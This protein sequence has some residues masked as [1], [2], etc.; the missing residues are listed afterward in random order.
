MTELKWTDDTCPLL[1][2]SLRLLKARKPQADILEGGLA[3]SVNRNSAVESQ[4][5]QKI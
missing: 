5:T 1:P 2:P 4:L 3:R